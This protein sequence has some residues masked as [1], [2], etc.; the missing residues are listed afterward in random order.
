MQFDTP[1]RDR[2]LSWADDEGRRIATQVAAGH[3]PGAAS[4]DSAAEFGVEYLPYGPSDEEGT[5]SCEIVSAF[6]PVEPEY[7]AIRRGVGLLDAPHR[8]TI[9][10]SGSDRLSF[11]ES[12][13]TQKVGDLAPG[14]VRRSFWLNR[15]G[16]IVSD[17]VVANFAD[18]CLLEID[19]H[20]AEETVTTLDN[21]LFA[22]DAE[23]HWDPAESS[24]LRLHGTAACASLDEVLEE[25]TAPG[26]DGAGEGMIDQC[27]VSMIRVDETGEPGV[28]IV[29]RTDEAGRVWDRLLDWEGT[30]SQR[31]RPIG[32]SAFNTARIEAG[33]PLFNIDFGSDAIPHETGVLDDRVSFNKGCYLGQELVARLQSLGHP[34]Q[35]LVGLDLDGDLLPVAGSQIFERT[36]MSDGSSGLGRQV[37]WV[38]SS[39]IAPMLGARPVAMA[40]VRYEPAQ[41]GTSLFL[42]AEGEEL[43]A[44][45]REHLAFLPGG[46]S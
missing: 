23:F 29:V 22:E 16:R 36:T 21:Y 46:S 7:A 43:D 26:P 9:R 2:H 32:W 25:G 13:I 5:P 34:K 35:M 27:R 18:H 38:T 44:V 1:L 20:K 28:A 4:A 41:P 24:Q 19:V 8:T 37:G 10:L 30:G 31:I 45:V 3:R 39:T 6:G 11:L 42:T 12:M 33:T 14:R 40:M 17:L 15:K